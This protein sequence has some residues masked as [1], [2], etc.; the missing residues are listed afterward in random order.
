MDKVPTFHLPIQKHLIRQALQDDDFK[1][2][3]KGEP[4]VFFYEC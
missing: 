1:V 4:G 3:S 2:Q